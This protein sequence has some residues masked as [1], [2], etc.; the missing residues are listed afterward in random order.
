MK[1]IYKFIIYSIIS[2]FISLIVYFNKTNCPNYIK[3]CNVDG[4]FPAGII[5]I[6]FLSLGYV[7]FYYEDETKN[8]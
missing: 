2:L 5:F 3:Y 4:I 6:I 8:E 1:K 7:Y